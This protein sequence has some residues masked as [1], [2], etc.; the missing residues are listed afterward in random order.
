MSPHVKL[1]DPLVILPLLIVIDEHLVISIDVPSMRNPL[2]LNN[3]PDDFTGKQT[4]DDSS[5]SASGVYRKKKNGG[6]DESGKVYECRFCSLKFCKS[7]ALG[8]HMNR[9][10]Q[11]R[12]TETL[13]RARQL[14]FSNDNILPTLP[15][16][17]GGQ[18]VVHGG[19]HHQAG[20][21]MGSTV[22][23][24]RLFSGTSTT[25]L[26]PP[27]PPPPS[28]P[29]QHMYTS[30]ASRLNNPYSSQYPINDYFIGHVCSGNPPSFS[31]QTVP[32]STNNYTCVGAPIGQSFT[33]AGGSGGGMEMSASPV[34]RY[35][36]DGF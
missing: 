8:G 32:D 3:F 17:L 19:F 33:L 21:N 11:E 14:V 5:S 22:C 9:H 15:H 2:D 12:E 10:R 25:I 34:T 28:Q 27:P 7:Q 29:A 18:P 16:Q 26:P 4:L 24:T 36:Q 20:C 23:P 31:L 1:D 35:P 30:Q 6:E 13:N